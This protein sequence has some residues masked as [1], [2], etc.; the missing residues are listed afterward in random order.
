MLVLNVGFK[1]DICSTAKQR[2]HPMPALAERREVVPGEVLHCDL[3][4]PLDVAYNKAVFVLEVMDE[5]TRL[6]S[7]QA[8]KS[9]SD[10]PRALESVFADLA[11]HP[12]LKHIRN[13]EHTT[14]HTDSEVVLQSAAL[15]AALATRRVSLRAAVTTICA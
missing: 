11:R 8:I 5:A 12:I 4:G 13:G 9:K 2:K 7:M 10:V 3:K 14:V 15:A 6:T 1:S